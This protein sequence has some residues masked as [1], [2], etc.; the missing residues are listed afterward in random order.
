MK[1]GS[2]WFPSSAAGCSIAVG[3]GWWEG[4][5]V[6]HTEEASLS[7]VRGFEVRVV[8]SYDNGRQYT[9]SCSWRIYF[10]LSFYQ[11]LTLTVFNILF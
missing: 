9:S 2:L 4:E 8:V 7:V 3:A 5:S 1:T 11:P 6:G 10:E